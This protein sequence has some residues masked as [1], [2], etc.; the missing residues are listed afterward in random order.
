MICPNGFDFSAVLMARVFRNL[1]IA[2]QELFDRNLLILFD[3][4]I[5]HLE[6]D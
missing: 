5:G 1:V 2:A 3:D 6:T 4:R